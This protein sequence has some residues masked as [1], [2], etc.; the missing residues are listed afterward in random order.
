VDVGVG[1]VENPT[2]VYDLKTGSAQ[3]TPARVDQIQS[4]LPKLPDG[5]N[6][7]YRRLDRNHEEEGVCAA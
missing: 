5:G 1:T 6:V 2:M 4:H 3:L 7:R